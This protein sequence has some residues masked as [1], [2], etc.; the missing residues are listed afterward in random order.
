MFRIPVE[1]VCLLLGA[2]ASLA[3]GAP[4]P[5]VNQAELPAQVQQVEG[6]LVPVPGEIF[7]ALDRFRDSN[8]KAVLHPELAAMPPNGNP[9]K[10]ALSLGLVVGEGFIAIAAEDAT[11][12]QDLGRNALKLARALGVEKSVLAR[13]NSIGDHAERKDWAAVR[14][15]WSGVDADIKKAMA[16]IGSEPLSHLVSLGGWLRGL[17]ALSALIAQH[18]TA[19]VAQLIRQPVLLESFDRRLS[20]MEGKIQADPVVMEMRKG[21]ALLRP[22]IGQD[23]ASP[24]SESEVKKIH[25]IAAEL[26]KSVETAG[27]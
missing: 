23:Q 1:T 16:G 25:G 15:E 14:A 3:V 6:V 11:E 7:R 22:L 13:A 10:L 26:V 17:E 5:E 12:V 4:P 21:V 2:S 8:W 9:P 24:V 27:P 18:Y 19:D 20:H